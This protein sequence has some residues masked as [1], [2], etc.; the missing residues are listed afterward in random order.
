MSAYNITF[1]P[2]DFLNVAFGY[3]LR[4]EKNGETI[5]WGDSHPI[6]GETLDFL[7]CVEVIQMYYPKDIEFQ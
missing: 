5:F 4:I 3:T 7:G 6:T 1:G 2:T